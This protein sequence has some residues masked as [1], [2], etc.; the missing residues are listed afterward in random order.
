MAWC[1]DLGSK[2]VALKPH[3]LDSNDHHG[4]KGL[5]LYFDI[6]QLWLALDLHTLGTLSFLIL[7]CQGRTWS[8]DSM[9]IPFI[10]E[11]QSVLCRSYTS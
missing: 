6:P 1:A 7:Y 4:S 9:G 5:V 10:G 2:S 8:S 11:Y 3:T